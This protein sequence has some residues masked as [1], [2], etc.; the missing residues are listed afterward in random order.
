MTEGKLQASLYE[1]AE[2]H[3]PE[4]AYDFNAG[5]WGGDDED[6]GRSDAGRSDSG[7]SDSGCSYLV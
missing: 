1:Q 7:R 5:I 4:P 2:A 6:A 3:A